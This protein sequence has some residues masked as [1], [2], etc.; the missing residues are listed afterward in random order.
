MPENRP[1]PRRQAI[2]VRRAPRLTNV[3]LIERFERDIRFL[4]VVKDDGGQI[5]V[6]NFWRFA[7]GDMRTNDRDIAYGGGFPE[8]RRAMEQVQHG[9]RAL[10]RHGTLAAGNL[11]DQIEKLAVVLGDGDLNLFGRQADRLGNRANDFRRRLTVN[12]RPA[13]IAQINAAIR[14]DAL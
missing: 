13:G 4:I 12:L 10:I 7:L 9:F 3:D 8:D 1:Q 6:K 11:P 5:N 14:P 2:V